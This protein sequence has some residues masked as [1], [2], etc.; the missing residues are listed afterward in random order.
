MGGPPPS[1]PVPPSERLH[2][3]SVSSPQAVSQVPTLTPSPPS[4]TFT[5]DVEHS[6][7]QSVFLFVRDYPPFPNGPPVNTLSPRR[8]LPVAL[9][10]LCCPN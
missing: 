4:P 3:Q 7:P 8:R 1:F 6:R 9:C 10:G 5:Y 2:D